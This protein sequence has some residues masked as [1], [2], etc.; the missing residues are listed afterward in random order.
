MSRFLRKLTDE[1]VATIRVQY[2]RGYKS[3]YQLAAEH[4]VTQGTIIGVVQGSTYKSA[5]GPITWP[6]RYDQA[7]A[8]A[9]GA[10]IASRVRSRQ[11]PPKGK[12]HG[13]CWD[14]ECTKPIAT[15]GWAQ[16]MHLCVDC[17]RING[18][19]QGR[20]R[21]GKLRTLRCRVCRNPFTVYLSPEQPRP[22]TCSP[23][24]AI[25]SSA[26]ARRKR[27]H[28]L[29]DDRLY[30]LY[31]GQNLTAPEIAARYDDAFSKDSVLLWLHAAGI[32][33]RR[34]T[35]RTYT[36]CVVEG[37]AQPIKK[38]FN[39]RVWYGRLCADHLRER[40]TRRRHYYEAQLNEQRGSDL[41]NQ[42]RRLLWGLP[43]SVKADAEQ[44]IVIAV[45][46]GEITDV[47]RDSIKPYV[48]RVFRENAD[49]YKFV[50]LAAPT[51]AGEE[52]QTWGER[53]GIA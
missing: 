16:R 20:H 33:P 51:R 31:W 26:D 39:G 11:T 52:A 35:S 19:K 15:S 45:L 5:G 42:I 4:V 10:I 46:S 40:D 29:T 12:N 38:L 3:S 49:A 13:R 34:R 37:C 24:C 53:L 22:R 36:T 47:T 8:A 7:V 28:D 50:S 41:S 14:I 32:R 9:F 48:A 6:G 21:A 25:K 27:P 1:Q 23:R 18:G 17:F 43:E 30:E 2:A 44:E